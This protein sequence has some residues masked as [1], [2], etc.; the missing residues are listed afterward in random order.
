MKGLVVFLL[1]LVG[2]ASFS[3]IAASMSSFNSNA[4]AGK[5]S[6]SIEFATFTLAV[7]KNSG[8]VVKCM[9]EF[10]VNCNG[11]IS[12]A[13]DFAECSGI[14]LEAPKALGFAVF[15]DEWKDP[16]N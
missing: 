2:L 1:A 12:K 3:F 4:I 11:K 7:C 5:E 6:K 9:D 14:K 16:R 8:N 15:G 10:F 13:A